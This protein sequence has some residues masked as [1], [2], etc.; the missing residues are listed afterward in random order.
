MGGGACGESKAGAGAKND[1]DKVFDH[2]S[3]LD[4]RSD[5]TEDSQDDEDEVYLTAELLATARPGQSKVSRDQPSATTPSSSFSQPERHLLESETAAQHLGSLSSDEIHAH[6]AHRDAHRDQAQEGAQGTVSGAQAADA[7]RRRKSRSRSSATAPSPANPASSFIISLGLAD[8]RATRFYF[9]G[10][11]T[12]DPARCTQ[13]WRG[14]WLGSQ[15]GKPPLEAF[16]AANTTFE[17]A[18]TKVRK[19]AV[20]QA[21]QDETMV[22]LSGYFKVGAHFFTP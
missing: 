9:H 12:F 5:G 21:A 20:H 13:V 14:T 22:P 8:R 4:E 3:D 6:L 16:R 18:T 19:F 2:H 10:T 15:S 11:L 7:P 1:N 17:Y